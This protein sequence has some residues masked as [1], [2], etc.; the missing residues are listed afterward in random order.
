MLGSKVSG[1]ATVKTGSCI[2]M[3]GMYI[4][5]ALFILQSIGMLLSM[6]LLAKTNKQED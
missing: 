6:L 1:K 4:T 2:L 5:D 3:L